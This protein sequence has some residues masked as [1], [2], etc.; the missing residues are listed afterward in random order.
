[1][2]CLATIRG[3][4]FVYTSIV[5]IAMLENQASSLIAGSIRGNINSGITVALVFIRLGAMA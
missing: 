5:L 4:S 3:A 2:S 1:M